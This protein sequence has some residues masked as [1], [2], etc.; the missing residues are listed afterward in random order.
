MVVKS[1]LK[2]ITNAISALFIYDFFFGELD[3]WT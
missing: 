3:I 1:R 2:N